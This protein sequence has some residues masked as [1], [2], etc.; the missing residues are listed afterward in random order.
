TPPPSNNGMTHIEYLTDLGSPSLDGTTTQVNGVAVDGAGNLYATGNTS[1]F[2][3]ITQ[4]FAGATEIVDGEPEPVSG[5]SE[6]FVTK[7]DPSGEILYADALVGVNN[8]FG[9]GIAVDASGK[10]NVVGTTFSDSFPTTPNA[11]QKEKP[12][13]VEVGSAFVSVVS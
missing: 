8:D 9:N 3:F 12:S 1:A 7:L 4:T 2:N 10:A 13:D 11:F 5:G 6:A